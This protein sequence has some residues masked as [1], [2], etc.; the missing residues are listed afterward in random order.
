MA[1]FSLHLLSSW[2]C[3]GEEVSTAKSV[4]DVTKYM[5]VEK[6]T[7]RTQLWPTIAFGLIRELVELHGQRYGLKSATKM[8]AS[9]RYTYT[10]V[11]TSFSALSNNESSSLCGGS[12][13]DHYLWH[14]TFMP[15]K[16]HNMAVSLNQL[17]IV[18]LIL[19]NFT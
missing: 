14:C 12:M 11:K 9:T 18:Y 15:E 7:A 8:A 4:E 17:N 1:L 10:L 5:P 6:D 2:F 3:H 13:S 16:N 19:T